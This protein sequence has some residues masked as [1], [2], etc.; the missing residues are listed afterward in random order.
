MSEDLIIEEFIALL[1]LKTYYKKLSKHIL[2]HTKKICE[3]IE[4][5]EPFHE[6]EEEHY[7]ETTY[8]VEAFCEELIKSEK[9]KRIS[10]INSVS[11]KI[12]Y[13]ISNISL[14]FGSINCAELESRN[15]KI[16][17]K[18]LKY[19]QEYYTNTRYTIIRE[20]YV[21]NEEDIKTNITKTTL[22]V[23]Y[24]EDKE[25]GEQGWYRIEVD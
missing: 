4:K 21:D 6:T 12:R 1:N 16:N 19:N 11:I 3:M 20:I 25:D 5:K 9:A 18:K 23:Y 22:Y 14:V 24:A 7:I 10:D 2:K 8:M 13:P 15:Y 17:P